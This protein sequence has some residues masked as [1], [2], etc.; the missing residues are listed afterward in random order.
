MDWLRP[1]GADEFHAMTARH[2]QQSVFLLNICLHTRLQ[3]W[4]GVLW[5]LNDPVSLGVVSKMGRGGGS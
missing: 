3:V 1:G 4:D 2:Q 5:A